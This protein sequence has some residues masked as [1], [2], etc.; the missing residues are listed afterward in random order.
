MSKSSGFWAYFLPKRRLMRSK[1][2]CTYPPAFLLHFSDKFTEL[3]R[4]RY[5]S[6]PLTTVYL[7]FLKS[8]TWNEIMEAARNPSLAFGTMVIKSDADKANTDLRAR[9]S[10]VEAPKHTDYANSL[11]NMSSW[12][13]FFWQNAIFW[14]PVM[15]TWSKTIKNYQ[16]ISTKR[17]LSGRGMERDRTVVFSTGDN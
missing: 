3:H 8:V 2:V 17:L 16:A 11:R 1:V 13:S 9:G 15:R 4:I 12:M 7:L 14:F 5:D 6:G 10:P